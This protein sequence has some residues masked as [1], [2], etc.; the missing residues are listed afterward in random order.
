MRLLVVDDDVTIRMLLEMAL[1]GVEVVE[2]WRAAGS[3]DHVLDRAPDAVVI[4]RRLP[5]GDGLAVVRAIRSERTTAGLPIVV[6]TASDA[7]EGRQQAFDAGADEHL[8]KPFDPDTLLAVVHGLLA[9]TEE[10]RRL[11]RTLRRAR[12]RVGRD[13]GGPSDLLPVA[14]PTPD[15]SPA[16]APT[17]RLRR[18]LRT[19]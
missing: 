11:R 5:D 15:R 6:M 17:G 14:A 9:A 10:E 13:D 18:L 2:G 8:V 3:V 16:A 19:G 7:P 1:D 4:D 12:L